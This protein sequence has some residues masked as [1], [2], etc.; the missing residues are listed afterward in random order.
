L[1]AEL[2]LDPPQTELADELRVFQWVDYWPRNAVDYFAEAYGVEVTVDSYLSNEELYAELTRAE[3]PAYDLV[4]PS[5]YMVHRL[6]HESRIQSLDLSKIPNWSGLED[7]WVDDAPYDPGPERYSAPYQWGTT[8]LGWHEDLVSA[9]ITSWDAM[10][11]AS[12]DVGITWLDD[13]REVMGAALKRLGYSVNTSNAD[14]IAEA[15]QTI[16][17]QSVP[18]REFTSEEVTDYLVNKRASPCHIWSGQALRAS[19]KLWD[20]GTSPIKYKVPEE[21]GI[22]W[23]DTAVI[24]RDAPHPDTAHAFINYLL[25]PQIGGLITN[26]SRNATPNAAAKPHVRSEQLQ[27]D[28]LYPP[29]TVLDRLEFL[30][31]L[32]ST[33]ETYQQAWREIRDV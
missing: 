7:R 31:A 25:A 22:A 9:P 32:G 15:K 29:E 2:G 20:D 24:P 28:A 21:G 14:A 18:S 19:V 10:W 23:I 5:D 26:Y 4:F 27:N 13:M 16:L 11:D 6:V 1:R 33:R 17:N 12:N 30:R 8:G 3:G